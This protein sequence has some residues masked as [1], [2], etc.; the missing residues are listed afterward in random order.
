MPADGSSDVTRV[1]RELAD[2]R[3]GAADDLAGLVYDELRRLAGRA[4]R[5]EAVGHTLQPTELVHEAFIALVGRQP[6]DWQ[7]R[8][9]FYAVA[10]TAMRRILIDHARRRNAR[11]RDSGVRVT[12]DEGIARALTTAPLD[13]LDMIALEDALTRLERIDPRQARI[14]ELRF[15][16][17]LEIDE[18]AKALDVSPAT[19]KRDWTFARAFLRRELQ[20]ENA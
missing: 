3:P 1:L 6:V 8:A 10:V 9:H 16:A 18:T 15:F 5:G 7:S 11:K 20:R 13:A 14:V 19:V 4:L 17:G 2:G 12:F